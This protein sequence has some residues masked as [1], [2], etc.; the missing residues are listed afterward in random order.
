MIIY[1]NIILILKRKQNHGQK[2]KKGDNI[3][4]TD[5]HFYKKASKVDAEHECTGWQ[6]AVYNSW[7]GFIPLTKFIYFYFFFLCFFFY[8]FL[9]YFI[10]FFILYIYLFTI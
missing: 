6:T 5:N 2:E 3:G 1:E 7:S 8:L 10:F 9:F 4:A